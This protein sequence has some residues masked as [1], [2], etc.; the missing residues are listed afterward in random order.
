MWKSAEER[1]PLNSPFD[2][3]VW[4]KGAM[5]VRAVELTAKASGEAT[6]KVTRKVIDA[7]GR[8]VPVWT[9]LRLL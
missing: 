7:R 2:V 5:S 4:G 3:S 9:G 6:V 8:T 1:I